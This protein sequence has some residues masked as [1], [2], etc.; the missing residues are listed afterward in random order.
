MW[1]KKYDVTACGATHVDGKIGIRYIR[2]S[3]VLVTLRNRSGLEGARIYIYKDTVFVYNRIKKTYYSDGLPKR[4]FRREGKNKH[5][6][7]LLRKDSQKTY[8]EYELGQRNRAT[9]YI[10]KFKEVENGYYLPEELII[11]VSYKGGSYC[12]HL[13]APVYQ[14]NTPVNVKKINNSVKYRK[15]KNLDEVLW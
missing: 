2:D 7:E 12:Y 15:V 5:V 14:I 11:K 6:N 1:I 9:I 3:V 10:K 8:F 4:V 13:M